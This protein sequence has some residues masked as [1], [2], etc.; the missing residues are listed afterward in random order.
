[1]AQDP[2]ETR[3]RSAV[4]AAITA[5]M[6]ERLRVMLESMQAQP[7]VRRDGRRAVRLD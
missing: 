5:A 2:G 7:S 6:R 4:D 1:V 3:E